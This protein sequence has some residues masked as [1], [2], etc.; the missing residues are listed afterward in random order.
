MPNPL[1]GGVAWGKAYLVNYSD[2]AAYPLSLRS[3]ENSPQGAIVELVPVSKEALKTT[4][5][6]L[7]QEADDLLG[8]I[9]RL[10]R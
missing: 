5:A 7:K 8:R 1:G 4:I 2:Y 10:R 9:E 6:A 3:E